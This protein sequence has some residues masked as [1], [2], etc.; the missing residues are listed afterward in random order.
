MIEDVKTGR[1]IT[2]EVRPV[3]ARDLDGLGQG[4]RFDWSG[5]GRTRE[6]FKLI[7]PAT[8]E[9]IL[10]LLAL[11]RCKKYVEVTLLESHPEHVGRTKRFG[12]IAGSLLAFAARLS[13]ELGG[14]G[15]ISILAK[16]ELIEHYRDTYGFQRV[17]N[18]QGMILAPRD[19]ARLI[20]RYCG[21]LAHE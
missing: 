17:G 2:T 16:T 20:E 14:E 18:S 12:G 19:A 15:F 7:D 21:R 13:F 6:V 11:N 4:W 10:G 3:E 8:P 9:A 5:E 1:L